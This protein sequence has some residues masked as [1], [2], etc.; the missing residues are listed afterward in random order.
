MIGLIALHG[1]MGARRQ[2]VLAG[3]LALGIA[4]L[5]LWQRQAAGWVWP[6]PKEDM[7]RSLLVL[8]GVAV[9]LGVGFQWIVPITRP[10]NLG[11]YLAA[12]G[13]LVFN[14]LQSAGISSRKRSEFREACTAVAEDRRKGPRW[15]WIVAIAY[16]AG[17]VLVWLPAIAYLFLPGAVKWLRENNKSQLPGASQAAELAGLRSLGT[18]LIV[19]SG[20]L[21]VLAFVLDFVLKIPLLPRFGLHRNSRTPKLSAPA[22]SA[23]EG[24]GT[25]SR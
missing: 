11:W 2:L 20:L 22:V 21:I 10:A 19:A 13:L 16:Q 1:A 9:L 23:S 14:A 7:T 3:V 25:V 8:A 12:A 6:G 24:P 18:A 4:Q 17:F 5:S 15:K